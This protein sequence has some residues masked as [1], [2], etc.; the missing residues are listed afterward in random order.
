MHIYACLWMY[1]SIHFCVCRRTIARSQVLQ[2]FC[3]H[4]DYQIFSKAVIL[5]YI[6]ITRLWNSLLIYILDNFWNNQSLSPLLFFYI[7][8]P[9]YAGGYVFACHCSF[10][11]ICEKRE[12]PFESSFLI[13]SIFFFPLRTQLWTFLHLHFPRNPIRL[14]PT[15]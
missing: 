8:F 10:I 5:F 13:H 9:P 6:L 11:L 7:F 4:R 12:I 2:M 14:N 15:E 3:C 1:T